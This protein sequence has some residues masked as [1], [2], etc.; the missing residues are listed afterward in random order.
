MAWMAA[1]RKRVKRGIGDDVARR[2]PDGKRLKR[3]ME[4]RMVCGVAFTGVKAKGP[5]LRIRKTKPIP[6]LRQREPAAKTDRQRYSALASSVAKALLGS[7]SRLLP[8]ATPLLRRSAGRPVPAPFVR[9][10]AAGVRSG[11]TGGSRASYGRGNCTFGRLGRVGAKNFV[12][13]RGSVESPD[14][15]L[16]FIR[17]RGLDERESFGFLRFVV[18]DHLHR[19][20]DGVFGRE[21]LFDC[22]PH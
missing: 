4:A 17:C 3:K 19:I 9:C 11:S 7:C 21:P 18:P 1:K 14:D 2:L 15:G 5:T 16:H 8:F 13:E 6:G 20:R 22:R 10:G 12:F